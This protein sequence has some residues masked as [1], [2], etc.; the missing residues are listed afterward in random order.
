ME[1][2]ERTGRAPRIERAAN[3]AGLV[4]AGACLAGAMIAASTAPRRE[5]LRALDPDERARIGRD[6]AAA[7]PALRQRAYR[8]FPG[9]LWAQ[10]EH[11]AAMEQ[12]F[13]RREA[14]RRGASVGDVALAI[15]EDLRAHP[16]DDV[17]RFG[18]VAPCQPLPFYD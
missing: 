7:E 4:V 9:H 10:G 12:G 1:P 14:A 3:A 8:D 15:D 13:V 5:P 6:F 18:G 11:F 17:T 16:P 2:R